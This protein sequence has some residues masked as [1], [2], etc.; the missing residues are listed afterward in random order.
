MRINFKTSQSLPFYLFI[1]GVYLIFISPGLLSEG[2]FSDGLFYSTIAK[3]LAN[4]IGSFWNPHFTANCLTDFH[5]HPPLALGTQSVFFT[6]LGD[7]WYVD[8]IYSFL[9][10]IITGFIVLKIW[11]TLGHRHGWFPLFFWFSIP[12]VSWACKNNVL[13]NTL[14]IF[15]SV[16][17][18]FYLK[19]LQDKRF[20]YLLLSG[21]MLALGFL[22]KGFVAFFPWSLPFFWWLLLK[23]KPFRS[24][25]VDS[26][27]LFLFTVIPLLSLILLSPEARLSLQTYLNIQVI[28]SIKNAVTVDSRFF[29]LKKLFFELI[30]VVGLSLLFIVLAW[31]KGFSFGLLK[32]TYKTGLVFICLG[33]S[34]VLP[35]MISMKQSGIYILAAFPVLAIGTGI[36][37]YPL[38]EFLLGKIN[39]QS[40]GFLFFKWTAYVIFF[41]GIILCVYFANHIGR[42]KTKIEDTHLILAKL[43]ESSI[44]NISPDLWQDWGLHGYFGRYKNVCLDPNLT[45]KREFLLI[46]GQDSA[47]SLTKNYKMIDL[48]TIEY[49]LFKLSAP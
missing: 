4:G 7:S 49:K 38:L 22:T 11:K 20:F 10:F 13:E 48:P 18:L 39:Y 31:Q 32:K 30:P 15:T 24:M 26:I 9:T 2:M 35:V 43:P 29:I 3:N 27:S 33:L 17:V 37:L 16:S 46:K 8:K 42:D 40:K 21:Q 47:D 5:G 23:Q 28:D 44:I 1:T 45:N 6:L 25:M 41:A 12:L 19:S 34:A 36:L 14:M